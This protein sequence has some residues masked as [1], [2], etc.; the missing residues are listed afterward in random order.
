[1]SGSENASTR[2]LTRPIESSPIL[3]LACV[4]DKVDAGTF[5]EAL[6]AI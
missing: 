5:L 4:K 2:L 3:V 1:M 6:Q